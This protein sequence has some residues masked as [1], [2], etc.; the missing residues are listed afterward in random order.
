MMDVTEVVLYGVLGIIGL[1][2]LFLI[3]FLLEATIFY[4]GIPFYA[5][6]VFLEYVPSQSSVGTGLVQTSDGSAVA[7]VTTHKSTKY[8]VIVSTENEVMEAVASP[9]VFVSLRQGSR[10]LCHKIVGRLTNIHYGVLVVS[11]K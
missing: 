3:V 11:I 6:V 4:D 8:S 7:V 10:V 9:E 1:V 5:S 2:L